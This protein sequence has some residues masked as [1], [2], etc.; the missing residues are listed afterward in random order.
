MFLIDVHKAQKLRLRA[1]VRV[2]ASKRA[3]FARLG[4]MAQTRRKYAE[5]AEWRL[6]AGAGWRPSHAAKGLADWLRHRHL[7]IV[8]TLALVKSI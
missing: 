3:V 4:A 2:R 5:L 8:A 7:T 6:E 1:C